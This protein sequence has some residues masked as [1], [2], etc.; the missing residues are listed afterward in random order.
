MPGDQPDLPGGQPDLPGDQHG[1]RCLSVDQPSLSGDQPGLH[2][3]RD[4]P[5]DQHGLLGYQDQYNG[6]ADHHVAE[7]EDELARSAG[8]LELSLLGKYGC[9]PC[10][11]KRHVKH[12]TRLGAAL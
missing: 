9:V 6:I 11:M 12:S 7:T 1:L 5:G 10:G 8:N 2:G 4:L 3:E